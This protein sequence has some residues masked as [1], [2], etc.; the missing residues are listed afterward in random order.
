MAKSLFLYGRTILTTK[1]GDLMRKS[2]SSAVAALA[3]FSTAFAAEI[4]I[5]NFSTCL[6][7]SKAGRKEQGNIEN[8]RK[9]MTSMMEDA[10]N[11]L[12]DLDAK[13]KDTEYLDSL[14][15]QAEEEMKTNYQALQE[16]LGRYQQQ[17]YQ[18][19]Q[20]ANYQLVH[21]MSNHIASA[22]EKIAKQNNLDCVVNKEAC[23]Y[24][25]SDF[26]VTSLVIQ[27]MDRAYDLETQ[28]K[29]VSDNSAVSETVVDE[30]G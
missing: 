17:F 25:H 2:F 26:D 16:D 22:S 5:V 28:E 24:T 10:E 19:M 18:L 29:K 11:K 7:E 6:S 4:G 1:K 12:K 13:F 15:P 27:E 3:L 14:S 8:L 30:A 9:Q 20:G 21:K 23:F